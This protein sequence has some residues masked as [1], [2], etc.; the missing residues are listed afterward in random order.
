MVGLGEDQFSLGGGM[1]R[2]GTA[3]LKGGLE[4]TDG[5]YMVIAVLEPGS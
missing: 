1:T 3:I 4:M 5:N 2:T